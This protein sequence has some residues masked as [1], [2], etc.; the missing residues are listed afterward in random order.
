[1]KVKSRIFSLIVV[2]MLFFT[3]SSVSLKAFALENPA[4]RPLNIDN[5]IAEIKQ[6]IAIV[7][8]G[9]Q[10]I[11]FFGSYVIPESYKQNGYNSLLVTNKSLTNECINKKRELLLTVGTEHPKSNTQSFHG[12]GVDFVSFRTSYQPAKTL[13]LYDTFKPEVG[14]WVMVVTYDSYKGILFNESKIIKIQDDHVILINP[15]TPE[16]KFRSGL[17]I[18][19]HGNFLGLVTNELFGGIN[20][21][22]VWKVHGAKLQCS[23]DPGEKTITSCTNYNS[24]W[25]NSFVVQTAAPIPTPS[26]STD[27]NLRKKSQEIVLGEIPNNFILSKQIYF[28]DISSSSNLNLNYNSLTP[29]ICKVVNGGVQTISSGKCQI[30]VFLKGNEYYEDAES[31]LI[32]FQIT[33]PLRTIQCVKGKVTKKVIGVN[34]KCPTG[35]QK[36]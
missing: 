16:P 29:Y 28:L 1:M 23:P 35:Y 19:S 36:K 30:E 8:C 26:S 10:G 4:N 14:W 33:L 18:S 25:S 7:D 11:G 34:P 9:H 32:D 2:V 12:T 15:I 5:F 27:S 21:D 6:K 3:S 17:V 22:N 13:D 24:I 20:S 31:V